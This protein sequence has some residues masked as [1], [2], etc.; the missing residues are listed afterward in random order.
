[1]STTA[2]QIPLALQKKS[3]S[4]RNPHTEAAIWTAAGASTTSTAARR[5]TSSC[6]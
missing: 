3:S 5:T 6:M 1:M 2:G 4:P